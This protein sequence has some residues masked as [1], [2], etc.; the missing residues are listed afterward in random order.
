MCFLVGGG[1]R[2]LAVSPDLGPVSRERWNN[3]WIFLQNICPSR[4][5]NC[6]VSQPL[7]LPLDCLIVGLSKQ[8]SLHFCRLANHKNK[9]GIQVIKGVIK[10]GPSRVRRTLFFVLVPSHSISGQ[11]IFP[12][13]NSYQREV[14]TASP[15]RECMHWGFTPRLNQ[16]S[17][18]ICLL[19]F[20]LE[21][22]RELVMGAL[23]FSP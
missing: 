2:K 8:Q 14:E 5:S 13:I 6:W 22:W 16:A 17:S 12:S 21:G 15:E 7:P 18:F 11:C 9:A 1:Y 3:W 10:L 19:F 20:A 23:S 4:A